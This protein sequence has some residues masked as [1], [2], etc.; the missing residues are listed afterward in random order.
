MTYCYLLECQDIIFPSGGCYRNV[1]LETGFK[2]HRASN[3]WI[4]LNYR[5]DDLP[6]AGVNYIVDVRNMQTVH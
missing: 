2:S 5:I 6:L 4:K 3:N 1:L